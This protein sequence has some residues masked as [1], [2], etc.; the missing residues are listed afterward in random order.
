MLDYNKYDSP[1]STFSFMNIL[2]KRRKVMV[3]SFVLIV[4]SFVGAAFILPP[5]YR[6]SAKVLVNYQSE[7]EKAYLLGV[8]QTDGQQRFDK[9]GAELVIMKMRSILEPVMVEFGLDKKLLQENKHFADMQKNGE[10]TEQATRLIQNEV[11]AGLAKKL[12]IEREK[13]TN[14]LNVS[15][16]DRDPVFAAQVVDKVVEE[17]IKQRPAI[18]KD[19]RAF[20]FFETQIQEIERQIADLEKKGMSYKSQEK[21]LQPDQQTQILFS[22]VADFDKELTKVRA[23]RIA[24]E[25]RLKVIREQLANGDDIAFPNTESSEKV[26]RLDY[27]NELKKTQLELEMKKSSLQQKYTEKHP[28]VLLVVR[29]IDATR[30][31]IRSEVNEIIRAEETSVKAL[32]AA[33]QALGG[34]MNQV[35]NSVAEL[36]RQEYELGKLTIGIDDLREVYSM[37]IKQRE[38][39]RITASKKEYLVQVR[40]LEPPSVA[41]KPVKPNKVLFIGIA[42]VLGV[43]ISIG[44]ALFIEMFDP[45]VNTVEDVQHCLGLP[46]L[47]AIPDFEQINNKHRLVPRLEEKFVFTKAVAAE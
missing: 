37:L 40:L 45:S 47:A 18:D 44:S 41:Y 5:V 26:G 33:E 8:N 25:A 3:I 11:I 46:I 43:I 42:L 23:E 15:F 17:Y 22:S 21:V 10:L 12:T 27:L 6:S 13:D 9:I 14:I 39:A 19:T 38:E 28:E 16:D 36:S 35:V 24:K 34:R 1:I 20:E 30:Q 4:A 32:Q 7:N 2:L 31:K 29:D